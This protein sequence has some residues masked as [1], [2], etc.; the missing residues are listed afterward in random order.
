MSRTTLA[1]DG[2]TEE[3]GL[4]SKIDNNSISVG[5][6]QLL[7][8]AR[9][10]LRQPEFLVC[11]EATASCDLETDQM[12]QKALRDWLAA[13]KCCVLTIAH[14]LETIADYDQIIFLDKGV[15]VENGSVPELMRKGRG[16]C[17]YDLV[18]TAGNET[19]RLFLSK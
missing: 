10:V 6:R 12:I 4:Q 8:L 2:T 17:F 11:D 9:V 5:E 13:T 18:A 14:R 7:C 15:V 19:L 3:R 1:A 16:G